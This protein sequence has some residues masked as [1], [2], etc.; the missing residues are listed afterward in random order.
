MRARHIPAPSRLPPA[1]PATSLVRRGGSRRSEID[2]GAAGGGP[3][4]RTG[5][6]GAARLA[7]CPRACARCGMFAALGCLLCGGLHHQSESL[8]RRSEQSESNGSVTLLPDQRR[9][10]GLR[11]RHARGAAVRARGPCAWACPAADGGSR[12]RSAPDGRARVITRYS[13]AHSIRTP[14][15]L[16]LAS[17]STVASSVPRLPPQSGS[18]SEFSVRSP[19]PVTPLLL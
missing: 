19:Y 14:N 11:A 8:A 2:D 16:S 13:W 6:G 1:R 18:G 7:G 5:T 12:R 10:D 9:S 17:R 15:S 4:H 3:S